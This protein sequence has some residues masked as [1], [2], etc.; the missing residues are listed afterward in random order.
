MASR[1]DALTVGAEPAAVP[2]RRAAV[3]DVAPPSLRRALRAALS[4][5]YFHSWRL[6]PANIV[7][8]AVM[9]VALLASILAPIGLLLL[10]FLAIPTAG[11][12]RMAARIARAEPVS[13]WDAASAW[14]HDLRS[15]LLVGGA[16]V[17]LAVVLSV[18]LVSGILAQSF[19][20]WAFA[21]LAFWGLV[22]VWLIAWAA[23]PLV[24][25]PWRATWPLRDRL[26]LAVLLV[27]AH[28]IRLAV[29]GAVLLALLIASSVAIV[30]ILTVSVAIAAVL[31]ARFVLAAADRLDAQL[32]YG[33]QRR[34]TVETAGIDEAD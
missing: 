26:R 33:E 31:D 25:D 8:S 34:L 20:G 5:L 9:I 29:L 7:W 23:W 32:G 11:L 30:A 1:A 19:A 14:R 22:A 17:L 10:T 16:F 15:T 21:T 28:P 18:N 13:F 24:C 6:V 4:D 2:D 12:F 27:I 3:R